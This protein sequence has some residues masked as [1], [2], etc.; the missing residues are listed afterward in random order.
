MVLSTA[1]MTKKRSYICLYMINL[2]NIYTIIGFT[3]ININEEY[4]SWH[5]KYTVVV[6]IFIQYSYVALSFTTCYEPSN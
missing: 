1:G 2:I 6:D 4:N 5:L 3:D